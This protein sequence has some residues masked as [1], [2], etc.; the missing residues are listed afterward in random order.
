MVPEPRKQTKQNEAREQQWRGI[1][2][3]FGEC[4]LTIRAFCQL[5]QLQE[6]AFYFW[7]RTLQQ[8]DDAANGSATANTAK[9]NSTR[10]VPPFLPVNLPQEFKSPATT[11]VLELGTKLTLRF[12]ESASATRIAAFV[13]AL[14]ISE[15]TV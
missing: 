12:E 2:R 3:R 4:Q 6:S 1:M 9:G 5:E 7:R 10:A 13:H 8:R 11:I 14:Q 15:A